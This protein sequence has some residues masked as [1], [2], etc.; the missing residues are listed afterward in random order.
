MANEHE[1]DSGS[2]DYDV[3]D[4]R[5]REHKAYKIAQ[6]SGARAR[7][8]LIYGDSVD[9]DGENHSPHEE[10]NHDSLEQRLQNAREARGWKFEYGLVHAR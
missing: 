10:D 5:T 2:D 6:E 9:A 7:R 8:R 3:N 4:P 1:S